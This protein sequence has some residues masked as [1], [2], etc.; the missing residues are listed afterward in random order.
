MKR[1]IVFILLIISI[2]GVS[3][4]D[5]KVDKEN[6]DNKEA[7]NT[8]EQT[9][10]NGTNDTTNKELKDVYVEYYLNDTVDLIIE[11]NN[12]DNIILFDLFV[13]SG[14]NIEVDLETAHGNS[15]TKISSVIFVDW[16]FDKDFKQL[17]PK[18][19]IP[20]DD[21][22]I[23][24]K[25]KYSIVYRQDGELYIGGTPTGPYVLCSVLNCKVDKLVLNTKYTICEF[26]QEYCMHATKN[27]KI[28]INHDNASKSIYE[29]NIG[30][31]TVYNLQYSFIGW[32]GMKEIEFN[33]NFVGRNINSDFFTL[34]HHVEKIVINSDINEIEEYA[35]S[36]IKSLKEIIINGNIK[37]INDNAFNNLASLEKIT[38]NGTVDNYEETMINECNANAKVIINNK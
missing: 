21:I 1:I 34:N 38:I 7:T 20:E 30:L 5:K 19:Y 27:D 2:V 35:F 26:G 8:N 29:K 13:T 22:T 17:V 36:R 18:D 16:Y 3:S 28:F 15:K 10:N 33:D 4:C 37:K 12:I 24:A 9:P 23:Y 25:E 32:A 31:A 11:Q 6:N 14:A